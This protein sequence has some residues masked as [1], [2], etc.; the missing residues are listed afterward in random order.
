MIDYELKEIS[1]NKN[2]AKYKV[3]IKI[4]MEYG[5]IDNVC[6]N[7]HKNIYNRSFEIKHSYN[8]DK[9]C[10]FE[11]EVFLHNSCIYHYDFTYTIANKTYKYTPN[12]PKESVNYTTPSW[13]QDAIIYH[14]FVDRYKKGRENSL[15]PIKGRIIHTDLSEDVI[16]D[17]K[18]IKNNDF[19][20]GDIEGIIQDLDYIKSL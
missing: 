17:S 10:Y 7:V 20:G 2:G 13:A 18:D 15:E 16:F 14:I 11:S 19:Y 4:P 1:K 5:F 6:F 9:F 8:D 3:C 12:N